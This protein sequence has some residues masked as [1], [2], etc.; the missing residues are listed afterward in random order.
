MIQ[1]KE[2]LQELLSWKDER[3][4]KVITGVRR[5][6]KST[7]LKQ[8]QAHLM[9]TGASAEQIIY[10][11]FELLEY[12]HLLD[13]KALYAYI[14]E[15]LCEK[16][17]TYIF[18]DEIQKVDAF[19]KVVDS[20]YVKDYTDVYITG[21][22]SHMLSSELA[23]LLSGRYVEV[24]M[25]PL[26]FSEFRE[27]LEQPADQAFAEFLR[28]GGLPYVALMDRTPE[29]IDAYL[30]GIYNTVIVK[31]IEERQRRKEADP[32]KRKVTDIALLKTIAR[33]LASVVGNPVSVNGVSDYLISSGRKVS[34][35]TVADYM[36]TLSDS[37]IFYPVD[38]FDIVG[39]QL[40]KTN[41]KWYIVD[42][43][44]RN[45]ILPR[46]NYDLGFSIENI[47]FFE[48]R[49]RGYKVNIGKVGTTEVDFVAQKQG[50]ITYFQVT[51]DMQNEDTFARE[52]APLKNIRDN[53]EKIVLTLDRFTTGNYEGIK[54][55][56]LIDWLEACRHF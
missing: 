2:Y 52:M 12:E 25:L 5:C 8:Y 32:T 38:R 19:E 43:G 21:S 14:T 54:V 37:Y 42:L 56:N 55:I 28:T 7:L 24:S 30:E 44:L 40:L 9:E 4:I 50:I 16:R 22:N 20:I 33:Y 46:K 18:L 1:R 10:I 36:E 49:R 48:L 31:D 47:V 6:G 13:Y 39:K 11:N 53:Y 23:T 3:V 45:H 35:N 26:S 27:I 29:K 51:A 34:P 17:M 15:R 41:K